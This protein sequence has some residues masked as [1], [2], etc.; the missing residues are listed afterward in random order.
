MKYLETEHEK[1]SFAM[2]FTFGDKE[3]TMTDTIIDKNMQ[4]IIQ[5]IELQTASEIRKS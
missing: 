5:A 3:K 1:K 4:Q 2:S